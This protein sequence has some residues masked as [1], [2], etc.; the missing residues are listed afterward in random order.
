M[1]DFLMKK[2]K[3]SL[4]PLLIPSFHRITA[5]DLRYISADYLE[6][7]V[8]DDGAALLVLLSA[9]ILN[10]SEMLKIQ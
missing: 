6:R 9:G 1:S 5:V 2:R 3:Y 10:N 4:I 8:N 7:Y